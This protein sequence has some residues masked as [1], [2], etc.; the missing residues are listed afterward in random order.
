MNLISTWEA[1]RTSINS[2]KLSDDEFVSRCQQQ[3]DIAIE[4][5]LGVYTPDNMLQIASG[6]LCDDQAE[7]GPDGLLCVA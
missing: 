3:K 4:V 6:I 7:S 5:S 2:G 1:N